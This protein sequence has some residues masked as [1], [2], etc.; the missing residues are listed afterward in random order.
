M[1]HSPPGSSV[2]GILQAKILEWVTILPPRGL[3]DPGMELV[4]LM[5]PTLASRFFTTS[6]TWEALYRLY[7]SKVICFPLFPFPLPLD[8]MV[9]SLKYHLLSPEPLP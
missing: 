1:D 8:G 5:S 7:L 6:I 3:P 2:H 9:V 4:F